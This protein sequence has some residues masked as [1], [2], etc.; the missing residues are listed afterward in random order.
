MEANVIKGNVPQDWR[1]MFPPV[2]IGILWI[3]IW[4]IIDWLTGP[5]ISVSAFYLPGVV[6]VAWF[7]GRWPAVHMA[8][9]SAFVWLVADWAG[10]DYTNAFYQYWNAAVRFVF[11]M[12]TAILTSEVRSRQRSEAALLQ[13]GNLLTSILNSMGDGVVVVGSEGVIIAFN[14]AAE[15]IFK[16]NPLGSVA[17]EWLEKVDRSLL[18]SLPGESSMRPEAGEAMQVHAE[19]SLIKSGMPEALHLTVTTLPLRGVKESISGW[20]LVISDMTARRELEREIAEVSEREQRRI[21][22]DLHDGLCQHLVSVSFAAGTLQADLEQ[23]GLEGPAEAA[24]EI[25]GL[26]G[27]AIGQARSLSH[28]LYPAGLEEG[29]GIALRTLL[30]TTYDRTGV[31]CTFEQNGSVPELAN[32]VAVHLYR[33]AQECVNNAL[34]HAS[35]NAIRVS[36]KMTSDELCLTVAD[37]GKG[38]S[39]P[40]GKK[41]IGLHI[42]K[43][44]ASL[45]GGKL[46]FESSSGKGMVVRCKVPTGILIPTLHGSRN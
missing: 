26:I 38:C 45:I 18:L 23:A 41:G 13:Q 7:S 21:G 1:R 43:N 28:G 24:G 37:D 2:A 19:V 39:A 29:L 3:A 6:Y 44:R 4:G 5:E 14:P 36:L 35:P 22:Q 32:G 31:Y 46:E 34:R 30:S 20:V 8:T 11:F 33:I 16:T 10:K 15:R 17:R 27:D 9:L 12:I 42:I 25:A 40:S